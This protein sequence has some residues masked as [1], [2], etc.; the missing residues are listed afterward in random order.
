[1]DKSCFI[2]LSADDYQLLLAAMKTHRDF[3]AASH[4]LLDC[5]DGDFNSLIFEDYYESWCDLNC[6]LFHSYMIANGD[7]E[8]NSQEP[9]VWCSKCTDSDCEK[10][11]AGDKVS[12]DQH[13][14]LY[15][16]VF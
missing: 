8:A 14:Q 12:L 9:C 7:D 2:Y 1:M 16:E 5:I 15:R 11:S 13:I 6:R 3:V 10:R 4:D